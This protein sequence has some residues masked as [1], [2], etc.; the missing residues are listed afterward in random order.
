[1]KAP[2]Y[3]LGILILFSTGNL[4]AQTDARTVN[5]GFI[6]NNEP[7]DFILE[8]PRMN[9]LKTLPLFKERIKS[10][11]GL[12]FKGFCQSKGLVFIHGNHDQ[13][14]AATRILDEM[15]QEYFFK[16]DATLEKAMNA[17]DSKSEITESLK[18]E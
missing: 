10:V 4:S 9:N 7:T 16:Y 13:L 15:G 3:L 1:M 17:C 6:Q 8:V 11:S 12:E 18:T 14:I 5:A 2:L